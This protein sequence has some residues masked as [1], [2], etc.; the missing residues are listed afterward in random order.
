MKV[1][2]AYSPSRG[3]ALETPFFVGRV[4]GSDVVAIFKVKDDPGAER[5]SCSGDLE[6][7]DEITKDKRVSRCHVRILDSDGSLVIVDHGPLGK[8]ST[9][10]TEVSGRELRKGESLSVKEVAVVSIPASDPTVSFVVYPLESR[11]PWI[12]V[13]DNIFELRKKLV[14][15]SSPIEL[16]KIVNKVKSSMEDILNNV[17]DEDIAN[18]VINI[19]K[20]ID[21]AFDQKLPSGA[22]R[23]VAIDCLDKLWD[24]LIGRRRI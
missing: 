12:I 11:E 5:I 20:E 23:N 13:A 24:A 7:I 6:V 4:P 10:G 14:S 16:T 15:T 17:E 8:G 22:L 3:V 19:L 9:N 2:V 1:R 21:E 18:V